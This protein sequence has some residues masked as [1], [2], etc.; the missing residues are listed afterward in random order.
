MKVFK[1]I[2]ITAF[3]IFIAIYLAF[4]F[5]LPNA[6]DLN[7][8]SP[9]I[10]KS[11]Q[12]ATGFKVQLEG[13]KVKTAWNLSAGAF[14]GKTDLN[15]PTG[16]KFAQIN[17]LQIKLSLLPLFLGEVK[18][19]KIDLDKI[20]LNVDVKKD[21]KFLLEDYLS[22]TAPN[23]RNA[24]R[25][26]D[27][28]PNIKVKKYRIS[29]VDMQ[30]SN[31]YSVKGTGLNITDFV[32]NK[33]I[34]VKTQGEVILNNRRQI[35]YKISLF[36]KI[37]TQTDSKQVKKEQKINVIEIFKDLY[38]YNVNAS[39]NAD[40][41]A[42]GSIEE[43]KING[44]MKFDRVSFVFGGKTFPSSVLGLEFDGD[45]VK[46]N[47][48]LY[49]DISSKAVVSGVFKN[50]KHKAI[51][52][53]VVSPNA[54]LG[55]IVSIANTAL[56][57]FGKK[58]LEGVSANGLLS[59]DFNIKSDFK[60][61]Q[62]SG[63]LKVKNANVTHKLYNVALK[64]INADIDFSQDSIR[65]KQATASLDSQPIKIKGMI[66]KN[67]NADISI[68]ADNLQLKGVLLT[69][70]NGKL[71]KDNDIAGLISAKVILKGRLDKA[72][73][74]ISVL[75]SGVNLKN[76]PTKTRIKIARI[77]A[78]INSDKNSQ[79][80][81]EL[82]GVNV[83]PNS[84][85][86]I[87][88][89]KINISFNEKDLNIEKTYLY[90]NGIKTN[91]SGKISGINSTPRLNSISVSVPNQISMPIAG[92]PGS[93][94]VLKGNLILNGKLEAFE[95]KGMFTIPFM[96]IPTISMI[97]KNS[98]LIFDKEVN[99]SCAQMQIANSSMSLN[100]LINKDFSKGVTV[101]NI[102]FN[103]SNLDLD[104][105]AASM[106][107]FPKSSESNPNITILDGK[108]AIAK[109]KVGRIVSANITSGIS[110]NN[111][112]LE[113]NNLSGDAYLGKIKGQVNYDFTGGKTKINI[114]GRGLTAG[115]ALKAISGRDDG[116]LGQLDFDSNIS[117]GGTA[118]RDILKS[119]NG[120]TG[121]IISNG[122]MGV[123]GKFEHLLYAQ[124]IVSNSFFNATLN[125]IAKAVTVKNTGVYRYMKGMITFSNGWANIHYIKTSGPSMSLYI[126]GRYYLPDNTANLTILGRISDDVV[127]V[128]GPIGEFSMD[129]A[130]SSIPKIGEITAAL[131]NQ[132]TTNPN[133]ENTDLIPD[134][135]P[136]TEFKT[137]DFKVIID[138]DVQRQSSVKSFKWISKPKVVP[139]QSPGGQSP[140]QYA[141][142][143]KQNPAA[144]PDFVNQLP[145][146]AN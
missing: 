87:S 116:I 114:S 76:R 30:S 37:P 109:F 67:A 4:L 6:I 130:I 100:A 62:S 141:P 21:G 74:K 78:N 53:R 68:L 118:K 79:G 91:L 137:K 7:Q 55:N 48:N 95:I 2:F 96:R 82:V 133:Y 107:N 56:K 123:L 80:K 94:I 60:K 36:S 10:T 70:G 72:K 103:S 132:Y 58:D 135:Y 140:Q 41:K 23:T 90:V 131:V 5:I 66:D 28:M 125:V 29:F 146:L 99:L 143:I 57:T 83:Y 93:N 65:I 71:L 11:I 117:L 108:G 20:L 33:K 115:P 14:I 27:N 61:I 43:P 120:N 126:T 88:A 16:K 111:N 136:K 110:L 134:L 46:I 13:L 40:L 35:D 92:Y 18:V 44:K 106:A 51:N 12:E 97:A 42:V 121:F 102:N 15:Y 86:N 32:L 127:R 52:L 105:L 3:S 34:K 50:G 24:L 145:D 129:K 26:S 38:R 144:I 138:G 9:Q 124:N 19:D 69:S 73:P 47:S 113:L 49:T 22:K 39:I 84:P 85:A 31:I 89:P 119:L 45:K 64:S 25:F 112:V 1:I 122:K 63:F 101:R 98:T 128:L 17:G 54:S 75:A 142:A 139:S 8:Y 104:T 59:A 77:I 81:A